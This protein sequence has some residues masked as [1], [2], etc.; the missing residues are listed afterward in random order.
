MG[1]NPHKTFR[2]IHQTGGGLKQFF[3]GYKKEKYNKNF[4][5]FCLNRLDAALYARFTHLFVRNLVYK[6]LYDGFKPVKATSIKFFNII[7][8]YFIF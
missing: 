8:N 4:N 6:V 3:F 5:N 7:L 1:Y 2:E